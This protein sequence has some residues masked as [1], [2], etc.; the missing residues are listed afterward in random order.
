VKV[1]TFSGETD[2]F[3]TLAQV[4]LRNR[5]SA[6]RMTV[7]A[8]EVH[9]HTP[10]LFFDGIETPEAARLISGWEVWVPDEDAAPLSEG[11]FY[12][13]QLVGMAVRS[14]E[15]TVAR[16]Q[17]V[18]EGAQ[19]PLLEVTLVSDGQEHSGP[20]RLVPFMK[21]F[22]GTVNPQEGWIELEQVWVLDT[23]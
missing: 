3:R 22:V 21:P 11:E 16:V 13:S 23:E 9:H 7:R 19:A 1:H 18:L 5:E 2:H 17:A 12:I 4:E 6:R 10:V 15:T 20:V 14:G 8:V